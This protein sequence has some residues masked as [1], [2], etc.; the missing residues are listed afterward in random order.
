MN[1]YRFTPGDAPVLMSIPHVGT[2][3]P[4]EIEARMTDRALQRPDTDWHLD[5]LYDFAHE[6]GI[7]I[8]QAI[9]SRYVV[10]L[11]RPADDA[12][13]YPGQAGTGLFPETDFSGTSLYREGR[14]LVEAEKIDRLE[15]FWLPYHQRLERELASLHKKFGVAILFDCHS[16]VST[17]PRLFDGTLADFNLGT[18]A[19][20]SCDAELRLQLA[21]ALG[22]DQRYR[23][24]VDGRFKG[25]FITRRYGAPDNRIHAFQMELS[26]ATYCEQRAPWCYLPEKAIKVRPSLRRMLETALLWTGNH[27]R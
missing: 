6:L 10:D 11:N 5:R 2:A 9:W 22:E 12:A 7:P 4:S 20:N 18:A 27:G 21:E 13:L 14:G 16:I 3:I 1:P 8:L 17:V 24:V 15:T 23:L 19:G 26:M 25:G